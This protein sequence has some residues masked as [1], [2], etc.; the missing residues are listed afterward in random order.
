[1]SEISI[2]GVDPTTPNPTFSALDVIV[3]AVGIIATNVNAALEELAATAGPAV[4]SYNFV[5]NSAD[6][7][8][9]VPFG[10]TR[11]TYGNLV[12]ANGRTML[13]VTVAQHGSPPTSFVTTN[14]TFAAWNGPTI[15]VEEG[16]LIDVAAVL[17]WDV[18]A[19]S[20]SPAETDSA[21]GYSQAYDRNG[22]AVRAYVSLAIDSVFVTHA[23]PEPSS[24]PIAGWLR[25]VTWLT[26]RG[27]A[28]ADSDGTVVPSINVGPFWANV[29][30]AVYLASAA[31]VVSS[32]NQ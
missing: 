11:K 23:S 16:D 26:V 10:S 31:V 25:D 8:L 15:N 3:D 30:G 24:R 19:N 17:Q 13:G 9:W 28:I 27:S 21:T 1:M 29:A 7:A 20:L 4:Y 12:D 5:A 14:A 2:P 22:N 6:R 32:R 18:T